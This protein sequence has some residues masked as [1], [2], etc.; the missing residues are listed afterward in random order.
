MSF[1]KRH[2]DKTIYIIGSSE[3]IDRLSDDFLCDKVSIGLNE[4]FLRWDAVSACLPTYIHVCEEAVTKYIINN[5]PEVVERII[6]TSPTYPPETPVIMPDNIAGTINMVL[7]GDYSKNYPEI[8]V[9]EAISGI[10]NG[11]R[12][13]GSVFHTAIF[14]ALLM[15]ANNIVTVGCGDGNGYAKEVMKIKH[16]TQTI[17]DKATWEKRFTE[18]IPYGTERLVEACLKNGIRITSYKT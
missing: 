7:R 10:D 13:H 15:G 9:N 1:V 14:T 11:Y 5:Y 18:R 4:S 2:T 6:A 12:G 8:K 3:A 17:T 16:H